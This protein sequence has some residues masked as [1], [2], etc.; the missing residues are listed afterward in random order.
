VGASSHYFKAIAIN[1]LSSQ[2][3][4]LASP[5]LRF[6][7]ANLPYFYNSVGLL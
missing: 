2:K 3:L 5:D 1:G 7:P 4:T 6:L